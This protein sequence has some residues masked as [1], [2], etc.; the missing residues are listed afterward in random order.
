[1]TYGREARQ[2][3]GSSYP[4]WLQGWRD[5]E[6]RTRTEYTTATTRKAY[7]DGRSKRAAITA[8]WGRRLTGA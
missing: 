3:W 5:F 6:A 7:E 1:M 8:A 4:A 2:R